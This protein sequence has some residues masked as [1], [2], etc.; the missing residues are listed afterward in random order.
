[1]K[2]NKLARRR[3]DERLNNL[4]TLRTIEVPSKGWIKAIRE[5]LGMTTT[6]LAKRLNLK[7]P[8]IIAI[9]NNENNLKISTLE[10]IA[11]ALDCELVYSLM[12]R[13]SLEEMTYRQAER[14]AKKILAKVSHNMA[15]EN[16]TP[17]Y[18]KI[19]LEDMIQELLNGSQ[20]RLWDEDE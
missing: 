19:E 3:L 20:A 5:A 16:Q 8:R 18:D 12:P 9:E 14:K 17:I 1:M 6:Q 15:L 10:K 11:K 4:G 7:Q 2:N 13:T